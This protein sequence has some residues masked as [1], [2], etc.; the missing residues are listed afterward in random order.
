MS[1][2]VL[3][4]FTSLV[5]KSRSH[6]QVNSGSL[7]HRALFS[8]VEMDG[9]KRY[10]C[11]I[12]WLFWWFFVFI[13]VDPIIISNPGQDMMGDVICSTYY[14][15]VENDKMMRCERPGN[16]TLEQAIIGSS[17]LYLNPAWLWQ[18][19]LFLWLIRKDCYFSW[20]LVYIHK[21]LS[22]EYL[23]VSHKM[24]SISYI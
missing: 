2:P 18:T 14:D 24:R 19:F 17:Q 9:R 3:P 16:L 7:K 21:F 6:P 11:R 10:R 8:F 22:E 20:T 13:C 1:Y 23:P 12:C 4:T 15:L 5:I